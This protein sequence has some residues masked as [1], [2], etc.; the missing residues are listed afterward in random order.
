MGA[1]RFRRTI[2]QV[3]VTILEARHLPQNASPLV[4]VKVGNQRKKTVVREKTDAPVYNEVI[5]LIDTLTG[6]ETKEDAFF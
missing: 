6:S 1:R 3:C 2:Y 5:I 4:V